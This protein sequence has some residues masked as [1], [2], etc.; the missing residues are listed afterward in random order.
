MFSNLTKLFFS[1]NTSACKIISHLPQ[2]NAIDVSSNF[3]EALDQIYFLY[4][5]KQ[6]EHMQPELR[7]FHF[8]WIISVSLLEYHIMA[9]TKINMHTYRNTRTYELKAIHRTKVNISLS[10]WI[11]QVTL[12]WRRTLPQESKYQPEEPITKQGKIFSLVG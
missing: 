6:T 8:A 11:Q 5:H 3:S 9:N 2:E 12:F 4:A 10:G 1:Q 7:G